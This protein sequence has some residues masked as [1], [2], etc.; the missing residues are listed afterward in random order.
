[1]S[2]LGTP[3]LEDARA[4]LAA[5]FMLGSASGAFYGAA[6]ALIGQVWQGENRTR[7]LGYVTA[8]AA[9]IAIPTV[10]A[11]GAVAEKFGWQASFWFYGVSLPFVLPCFAVP[12]GIRRVKTAAVRATWLEWRA[13]VM[14]YLRALPVYIVV[15]IPLTQLP[16]ML[17][18]EGVDPA[19]RSIILA[20][21]SAFAF[22][23]SF[24]FARL[25]RI[26]DRR[27]L[28]FLILFGYGAGVALLGL[29]TQAIYLCIVLFGIATGA[30]HPYFK[31]EVLAEAPVHIQGR[32]SGGI[33]SV[34]YV[35]HFFNP[36]IVGTVA[37]MVGMK[38]AMAITGGALLLW[39]VVEAARGSRPAPV[40]V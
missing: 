7:I 28:L 39:L 9:V 13:V 35:A 34:H 22:L 19:K 12:A 15:F 26:L 18:E 14:V 31:R 36:L 33:V 40:Q 30:V 37:A 20:V 1:M 4:V 5:R 23:S 2:G 11:S 8:A 38:A 29:S 16:L 10:V 32:A 17:S 6:T 24:F 25:A 3:Y 27:Q 21:P